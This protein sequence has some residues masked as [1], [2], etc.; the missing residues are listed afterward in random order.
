MKTGVQKDENLQEVRSKLE[1]SKDI[2]TLEDW[3][4]DKENLKKG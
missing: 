4:T 2:F 3:S 1:F